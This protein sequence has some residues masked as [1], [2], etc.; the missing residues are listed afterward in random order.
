MKPIDTAI[1]KRRLQI[2]ILNEGSHRQAIEKDAKSLPHPKHGTRIGALPS[3][4][5]AG[6]TGSWPF[7]YSLPW[8]LA[9]SW[10][11]LCPILD[12]LYRRANLP[13][14]LFLSVR[15][16]HCSTWVIG[17]GLSS[18]SALAIGLLVMMYPILCKVRYESLHQVLAHREIWK[19]IAFSI[20]VNWIVAPFLMVRDSISS[21]VT[22]VTSMETNHISGSLDWRGLSS[23]MKT[24]YERVSSLLD[25]QDVSPWYV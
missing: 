20:L 10:E 9:S 6:L 14:Y 12:Q 18:D 11:T 3:R 13:M 21:L 22:A 25:S 5:S 7:G 19:Q 2:T 23:P 16:S 8:P 15:A 4:L 17:T 24:D 1:P